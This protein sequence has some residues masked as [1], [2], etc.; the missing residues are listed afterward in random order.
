MVVTTSPLV[1]TYTLQEFWELPEPGD[2]SKLE[3]IKGVLYISPPPGEIHDEAFNNL[4]KELVRALDRASYRGGIFAPRAALWID[5]DT[6]LEPD[7]MYV[8]DELKA[9]MTPGRRTRAGIVV[10]NCFPVECRIRPEDQIGYLSRDGRPRNVARRAGQER[11][12]GPLLRNG[13]DRRLQTRRRPALRSSFQN[14][15]SGRRCFSLTYTSAAAWPPAYL[16]RLLFGYARCLLFADQMRI[17]FFVFAECFDQFL[18]RK[19]I[20]ACELDGPWP[21]ICLWVLDREFQIDVPEVA[22][23]VAFGDMGRF[24]LRVPIHVQPPNIIKG[25][26]LDD[27]RVALPPADGV[28]VIGRLAGL[29]QRTAI[30]E[31]LAVLIIGLE[32]NRND[33]RSLDNLARRRNRIEIRYAVSEATLRWMTFLQVRFALLVERFCRRQ[34]GNLNSIGA[35]VL[36]IFVAVPDCPDARQVGLAIWSL[37]RRSREVRF[38]IRR[39]R[40]PGCGV[41]LPLC[42]EWNGR[43]QKNDESQNRSNFHISLPLDTRECCVL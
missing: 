15:D 21:A 40:N 2:H 11:S 16:R 23:P 38:S 1:K 32:K 13:Q 8:S 30:H 36:K 28:T 14:R 7:L 22:A 43:P 12:R 26:G 19:K 34:H 29:G 39:P 37:R 41:V 42:R 31:D 5:E 33:L 25:I 6:Y 20:Q 9:Q 4:T 3:L 17:V 18:V 27:E 35:Q 10:E 24:G